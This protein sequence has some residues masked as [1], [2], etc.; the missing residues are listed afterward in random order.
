MIPNFKHRGRRGFMHMTPPE[1]AALLAHAALLHQAATQKHRPLRGKNLGL[2]CEAGDDPDAQRFRRAAEDLGAHVTH[3]RPSLCK[4]G[5]AA[6][7][8]HT[9]R[10]LGRLYQAIECQGMSAALIQQ[11]HEHAGVPV[12]DGIATGEHP[13]ARLAEQLD[14][15]A[16]LD[17]RRRFVLQSLLL[18]TMA[19]S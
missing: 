5:T 18:S 8:Q 19:Q 11:I 1:M 7:V 13:T 4:W 17:D 9:A 10:M 16:S 6:E 14:G 12:Y 15:G 2:L 3:I